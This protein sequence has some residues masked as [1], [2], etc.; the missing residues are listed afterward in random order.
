MSIALF[1][2]IRSPQRIAI[3]RNERTSARL[4]WYLNCCVVSVPFRVS[5]VSCIKT[6]Y[7]G[8]TE[9]TEKILKTLAL[10]IVDARIRRHF[11]KHRLHRVPWLN[12]EP[13]LHAAALAPRCVATPGGLN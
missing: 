11:W 3:W 12:Q 9:N 6:I 13:R 7:H 2:S 5:V 4:C 1:L 8:G 10:K